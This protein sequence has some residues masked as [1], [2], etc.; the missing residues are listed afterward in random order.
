M[1]YTRPQLIRFNEPTSSVVSDREA[2]CRNVDNTAI[3]DIRLQANEMAY[4]SP[5]C[6]ARDAGVM[7]ASRRPP[8]N[9]IDVET[10]LRGGA[11]SMT[12][13]RL[14][15][16]KAA[17]ADEQTIKK[18]MDAPPVSIPECS[19]ALTSTRTALRRDEFPTYTLFQPYPEGLPQLPSNDMLPGIDTRRALKDAWKTRNVA[20]PSSNI[21]FVPGQWQGPYGQSLRQQ[22]SGNVPATL[23][24]NP[25][26]GGGNVT[27]T[28]N[29]KPYGLL[30][31]DIW[32]SN[33][34]KALRC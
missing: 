27:K 23:T 29:N 17:A 18:V 26:T 20:K 34:C 15:H 11:N 9:L 28:L 3:Y 7:T 21:A 12:T 19:D 16:P 10:S 14:Y 30:L 24:T 5:S 13:C 25:V 33:G 32:K 6:Y 2:T 22:S 8:S 4:G 1:S 31:E